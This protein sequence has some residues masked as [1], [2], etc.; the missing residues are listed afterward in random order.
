M[1]TTYNVDV[2]WFAGGVRMARRFALFVAAVLGCAS[3]VPS[4]LAAELSVQELRIRPSKTGT[5]IVSGALE[6]ESTY[7]VTIMVELIPRPGNKGTL[8]FTRAVGKLAAQPK[9]V[10]VHRSAGRPDE[11]RISQAHRPDMD[12][13]Q[14]GDPWPQHGTFTPFD[15]DESHSVTLNGV[16]DDNGT[17]TGEPTTFS[18]ALA[19]FPVKASANAQGVW[20]VALSTSKGDSSWEGLGTTL[21]GGTVT[22]TRSACFTDRHCEDK[23]PC[24]IDTCEAGTCNNKRTE[25]PCAVER[26]VRKRTGRQRPEDGSIE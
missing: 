20:D 21:R 22:V 19:A 2:S 13:V 16:V 23:D 4:A 25:G 11:V 24:T 8:E 10:S 7:G 6:D 17:F 26:P 9:Q 14:L 12:I 5:V 3:S 18:G 1:K 15:T